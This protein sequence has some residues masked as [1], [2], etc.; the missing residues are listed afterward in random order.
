MC[1]KEGMK[2]HKSK[3][4]H[5]GEPI[6]GHVFLISAATITPYLLGIIMFQRSNRKKPHERDNIGIFNICL[7]HST[8]YIGP[9]N[10]KL[11]YVDIS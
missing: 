3:K 2:R 10:T 11:F 9:L 4:P 1:T 5:V 6:L 7:T 8:L